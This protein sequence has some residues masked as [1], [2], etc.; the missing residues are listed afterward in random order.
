MEILVQGRRL[1]PI[2]VPMSFGRCDID[3]VFA[4]KN[5]KTLAETLSGRRYTKLSEEIRCHYPGSLDDRLGRFLQRLKMGN[6]SLYL[7]F[8][9]QDGDSTFCDF[10]IERTDLTKRK[11]VYYFAIA[12]EVKYVGKTHESFVWRINQGYGHISPKNCYLDGQSTNCHVNPR[13]AKSRTIVSLFVCP[14]DSDSGIDRLERDLI[15]LYQ[16][17]W[18]KRLKNNR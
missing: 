2:A 9:N 3:N 16:P 4:E 5:N 6:D 11:G 14:I 18:N 1:E 17:E 7:R 12:D 8:L 10:S 13:V 15:D